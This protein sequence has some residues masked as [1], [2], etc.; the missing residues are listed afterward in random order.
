MLICNNAKPPILGYI[1]HR[2]YRGGRWYLGYVHRVVYGIY[3]TCNIQVCT[4]G[5]MSHVTY[6]TWVVF[7]CA[8]CGIAHHVWCDIAHVMRVSLPV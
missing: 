7:A 3:N 6:G 4:G 5:D 1:W 2:G 8:I